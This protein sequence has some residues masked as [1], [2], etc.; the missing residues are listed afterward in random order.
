MIPRIFPICTPNLWPIEPGLNL[1]PSP[2]H[3]T[4]D[5]QPVLNP[6]LT[7]FLTTKFLWSI[8]QYQ[9]HPTAH[10]TSACRCR[11]LFGK[12][13]LVGGG[14]WVWSGVLIPC[15]DMAAWI[16]AGN[17][18]NFYIAPGLIKLHMLGV[19]KHSCVER[20]L[21][22][23]IILSRLSRKI[24]GTISRRFDGPLMSKWTAYLLSMKLAHWARDKWMPF[25]RRHFQM[26]FL[27][28][29]Y[30]NSD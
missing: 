30:M 10:Q 25:H 22:C 20:S 11:W 3:P 28:W 23:D 15:Y 18:T 5:L 13:P 1:I 8:Q 26:H 27:E 16:L 4:Q 6:V 21:A 24:S 12:R 29:K 2:E 19:S 14:G 17:D 9:I 7:C